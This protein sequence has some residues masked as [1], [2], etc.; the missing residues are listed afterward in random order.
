MNEKN[1][2]PDEPENKEIVYV[3]EN[4]PDKAAKKPVWQQKPAIIAAS[5]LAV[6]LL[7]VALLIWFRSGDSQAGKPVPAPRTT[8][9]DEPAA[10]TVAGQTITLSPE[11]IQSAG[12]KIETVGEQLSAESAT[13]AATGVVQAN[14]YRETPA[15]SLVGGIV[16]RGVP[17]LGSSVARGQTVA[18]VFSDEFA[19]TQSRY[20]ALQTQ[21]NNARQN[22]ARRERLVRINQPGRT[23]L[24]AATKQLKT[25]EAQLDEMRRRYQRTAKLIQI[26]A[27]SREE[28]EQDTT[29]LRTAEAEVE[30]SRKRF[31][32]SKQLLDINPQT[33]TELEEAANTV[34]N[35]ESEIASVREK[36]RL[37]GM[38]AERI[39]SLRSPSQINSEISI[40]APISGTVTT[41]AVNVGT[42]VEANKELLRITDL[43]NVWVIA[44]AHER[45]LARVR[46]GSGAS[47]TTDALPERL[48]RGQVTYIDP[49]LDEATRTAQ[50]RIE[51]DNP[52]GVLK[53][54]MYVSVAFGA[55]GQA[56]R[57]APVIPAS[58][59]QTIGNR[60]I[61]FVVTND[62]NVFELRPVRLGAE[63]NGRYTVLEGLKVGD[64]IATEG[65]F[66]LR[67]EWLKTN[68]AEVRQ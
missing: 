18:V 63:S 51:L 8:S 4:E 64:K 3:E 17:E 7:G 38:P 47:V 6:V 59:T 10:E 20:I 36:L 48:F 27:S 41:R 15:I 21:L 16:R 12:I 32:R 40:P 54:G 46:V 30:E 44:Q 49:R 39:N 65:S 67:A 55:L 62:P 57:T 19:E 53:I 45:D 26:G 33:R 2:E 1:I 31:E 29:K 66:M 25:A 42:V 28:L 5:I 68:Q 60:Q 23:E 61:V 24:E 34:R 14:S 35:T 9:M 52:G 37:Y 13:T 58:A 11:Q 50:V 22:Y 56:E 43:S